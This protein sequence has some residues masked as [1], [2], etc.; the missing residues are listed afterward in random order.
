[1]AFTLSCPICGPRSGYEFRFGGE[2]K[3]PRPD[4]EDLTPEAWFGYVHLVASRPGVQKEWWYHRGG[5]GTWFTTF[6][7]TTTNLE[8][9]APGPEA[10]E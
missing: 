8:V 3:G 1:M 9:P 7:D 2:D 6:R 5:C 4:T 10:S